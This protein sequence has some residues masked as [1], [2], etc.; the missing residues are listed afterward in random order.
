M[1]QRPLK[2]WK[3]SVISIIKLTL[4]NELIRFYCFARY[5]TEHDESTHGIRWRWWITFSCLCSIINIIRKYTK[6][7]LYTSRKVEE[8]AVA[9][10]SKCD[11][12]V[13]PK[14]FDS[15]WVSRS[16]YGFW[17]MLQIVPK[18]KFFIKQMPISRTKIHKTDFYSV[19]I[20][21][22]WILKHIVK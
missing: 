17:V 1:I 13:Q 5:V 10:W 15:N 19:C 4:M 2:I 3:Q 18:Q 16:S 14:N 11:F 8:E 9:S 12:M 7:A 21:L 6:P 22:H 20:V